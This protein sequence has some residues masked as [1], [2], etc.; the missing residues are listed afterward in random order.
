MIT[1]YK[2]LNEDE[3]KEKIKLNQQI[4]KLEDENYIEIPFDKV[5]RD[6]LVY[7]ED[8][9]FEE[10]WYRYSRELNGKIIV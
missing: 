5:S 1:E 4:F 10:K 9:Y 6:S 8:K 3:F 7:E 2:K